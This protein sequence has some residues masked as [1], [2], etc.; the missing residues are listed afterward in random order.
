MVNDL[1]LIFR[2]Q[3]PALIQLIVA[4]LLAHALTQSDYGVFNLL[5]NMVIMGYAFVNFGFERTAL[6]LQRDYSLRT[7]TSN[8]VPIRLFIYCALIVP[9]VIYSDYSDIP[10]Y[11]VLLALLCVAPAIL[12]IKYS[13]DINQNVQ[14]DVA[15]GVLRAAPLLL[16]YPL[17]LLSAEGSVLL[18]SHFLLLL[19][20]YLLY[21]FLQHH[22][23]PN[24]LGRL[25]F[26]H[27]RKYFSLS[28][29]TFLGS[30][31]S[32]INLYIP[33]FLIESRL[34]LEN[35]ALY[36]V[37]LTLYLGF[38][39]ICALI[40]RISVAQY[41]KSDLL[42]KELARCI[43][44]LLPV[45]GAAVLLFA[46]YG[47]SILSLVFG[48][49]YSASQTSLLILLGG[50]AV[51]PVAMY[52]SNILIAR[53]LTG[54]YMFISFSAAVVNIAAT[55]LLLDRLGIASAAIGMVLSLCTL[56]LSGIYTIYRAGK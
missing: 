1:G 54:K 29:F 27:A 3:L 55:L 38:L 10:S 11:L 39:S 34:G 8:I 12:D 20:G 40:V 17:I 14:Q 48:A 42:L 5:K 28:V 41:L 31:A 51:S 15:L 23:V 30:V 26:T 6:N 22:H 43:K 49:P 24:L 47:K 50:L 52:F 56:S 53:G 37:S 21:V 33:T 25:D 19:A 44:R 46:V 7:I 2:S 18:T 35:L 9:I 36:S 16:L 45:W 13:F 32:Y 4:S